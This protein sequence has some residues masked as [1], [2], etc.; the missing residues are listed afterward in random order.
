MTQ[1]QA[2]LQHLRCGPITPW[3]AL[4]L[5]GCFRLAARVAELRQDGHAITTELVDSPDGK[6]FARYRLTKV[7]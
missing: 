6:R 1:T 7:G 3:A 2:I 5:Y 4:E